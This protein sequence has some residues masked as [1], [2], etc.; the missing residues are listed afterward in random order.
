VA[1]ISSREIKIK[2][3]GIVIVRKEDEE[4]K[5]LMLRS[6]GYW[7]AGGKG[8]KDGD[9]TDFETATRE[10]KEETGLTNDDLDFKWG[11]INYTTE[12]YTKKR[13]KTA[14]F[15]IAETQTKEITLPFN[16]EIGRQEHDE[17]RWC[18]FKDAKELANDR[19]K[20]VLDWAEQIIDA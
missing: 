13:N 10:V 20:K 2:S 15:F 5:Y 14:T 8:K 17:Y 16:P 9:E 18:D 12:P 1:K 7:E 11:K 4:Y 19:I 6:G 3:C